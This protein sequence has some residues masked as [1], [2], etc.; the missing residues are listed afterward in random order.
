MLLEGLDV[1][2]D[3]V[4]KLA[5]GWINLDGILY[6]PLTLIKGEGIALVALG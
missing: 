4:K 5:L 6:T 2:I 3:F 1:R